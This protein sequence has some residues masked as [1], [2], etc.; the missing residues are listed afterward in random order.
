MSVHV[1]I[2]LG[3]VDAMR[4]ALADQLIRADLVVTVGGT[5]PGGFLRDVLAD[6]TEALFTSV[7]IDPGTDHGFAVLDNAVPLVMLPAGLVASAAGFTAFVDP[8]LRRLQGLE[9]DSAAV[10]AVAER[11]LVPDVPGRTSL[12]PV[13]VVDGYAVRAGVPHTELQAI[14]NA[15]GLAIVTDQIPAGDQVVVLP[16]RGEGR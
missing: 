8:V 4:L 16:W 10:G 14:N 12:I 9:V 15:D 3:D 6:R 2:D 7:D 13:R 11:L 1:D 5:E